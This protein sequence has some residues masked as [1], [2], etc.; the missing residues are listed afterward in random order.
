MVTQETVDRALAVFD[1]VTRMLASV[2]SLAEDPSLGKVELLA[3]RCLASEPKLPMSRLARSLGVALSTSTKVVDRL[4]EK[5][6]VERKRNHGDRRVVR[7]VLTAQGV[8]TA[9]A[10]Q[11]QMRYAVTKMLA[12]LSRNKQQSFIRTWEEIVDANEREK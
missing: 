7:V 8:K 6:L 5:G 3:L 2:E 1:R 4:T 12:A 9:S 10:H 11:K